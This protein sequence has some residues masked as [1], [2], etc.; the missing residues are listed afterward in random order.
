MDFKWADAGP[1]TIEEWFECKHCGHTRN[2]KDIAARLNP[3][4]ERLHGQVYSD[5]GADTNEP[6]DK[7]M[8]GFIDF[9]HSAS[10]AYKEG[11]A[12]FA[13]GQSG[14]NPNPD[15]SAA[16]EDFEGGWCDAKTL[17][18]VVAKWGP[19]LTL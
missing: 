9:S 1:E 2:H 5:V 17:S 12:N 4:T 7:D 11:W 3:T 19:A 18:E 13:A 10:H 15:D 8:K 6:K 16:F 14:P